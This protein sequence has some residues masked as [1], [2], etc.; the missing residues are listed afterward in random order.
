MQVF[1]H[2]D[3]SNALKYST[4]QHT[5]R[6]AVKRIAKHGLS[7]D[8]RRYFAVH[9]T[10]FRKTGHRLL[11]HT[12]TQPDIHNKNACLPLWNKNTYEENPTHSF[13]PNSR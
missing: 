10:A 4:L 8:K 2:N 6:K 11:Y 12:T 9:L 1:F 7:G 3:I 5:L 13:I